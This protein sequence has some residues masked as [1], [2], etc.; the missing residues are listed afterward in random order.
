MYRPL[1]GIKWWATNH[2]P[3]GDL[4]AL[5]ELSIR[6]DNRLQEQA[7]WPCQRLSMTRL[8][9]LV[10][11]GPNQKSHQQSWCNW[12]LSTE[13]GV[14]EV[15]E[16][17]FILWAIRAAHDLPGRGTFDGPRLCHSPVFS[18]RSLSF[19]QLKKKT[20]L[21]VSIDS[22]APSNFIDKTLV[23]KIR[24]AVEP[25]PHPLLVSVLD[26]RLL[27]SGPISTQ[28]S[29]IILCLG[30]H[31]KRVTQLPEL[32]HILGFPWIQKHNPYID[33]STG[34]ISVWGTQCT[35]SCLKGMVT[36]SPTKV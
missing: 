34:S 3:S 36:P 29:A 22:G 16:D 19:G 13:E 30:H 21:W 9:W 6:T 17:V 31:T 33:C 14:L 10:S 7:K 1:G 28:T 23:Q 32:H 2:D 20:N 35:Q 11:V 15:G 25:L 5:Y 8:P 18:C 4:E 12:A 24:L 26:G 27:G